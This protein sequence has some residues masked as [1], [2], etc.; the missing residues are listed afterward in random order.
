MDEVRVE[1]IRLRERDS[2]SDP[3]DSTRTPRAPHTD[4]TRTPCAPLIGHVPYSTIA[5]SRRQSPASCLSGAANLLI[6]AFGCGSARN[7]DTGET[8][9]EIREL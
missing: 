1:E 4:P 2:V 6:M 8:E 9:G 3:T 7:H 5:E